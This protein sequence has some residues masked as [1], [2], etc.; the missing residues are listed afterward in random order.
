MFTRGFI[1]GRIVDDIAN[2]KIQVETRNRLGLFDLTKMAEDFFCETLNAVYN[3]NLVNL[4]TV[5]SNNPGLDLGDKKNKIAYQITSSNNS[6]KVNDT[7]AVLN[8][9][10]LRTY[11]K[12]KLFIIGDKQSKYT[13]DATNQ[14]KTNFIIDEDILDLDDLLR[15]IMVLPIAS[16]DVLYNQFL[17]EFRSL[18]IELEPVDKDGNFE[19]SLYNQLESKPSMP[20][21][22]AG[23]IADRLYD[24]E[25]N[26]KSIKELYERLAAVPRYSRELIA[27]IAERGKEGLYGRGGADWGILPEL[28]QRILRLT[29]QELRME[30]L[31]LLDADLIYNGE[32]SI[33]DGHVPVI[34]LKDETL[35]GLVDWIKEAGLSLRTFFN[36]LDFTVLDNEE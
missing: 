16:L 4:N 9:D 1:I 22:N 24:D 7:L 30:L 13:V 6:Q 14:A 11:T 26:L 2:L 23:K 29:Q 15:D 31:I 17:R 8:Q 18:K 5:R 12:V 36:L 34:A 19:S 33:D 27:I 25:F 10:Q 28:L 20:P 35:N 21:A 3:L 32:R